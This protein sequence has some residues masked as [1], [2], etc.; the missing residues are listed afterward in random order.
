MTQPP[1]APRIPVVHRLHGVERI[2]DYDWMR[3]PEAARENLVAERR[4]YAAETAHLAP[5][6]QVLAA[7][8]A[9]RTPETESSVSW[10][11]GAFVYYTQIETGREFGD[12]CR[13]RDGSDGGSVLLDLDELATA[14]Y[15]ELGVREIS[16]CGRFLAYSVD[17]SGEEVYELRFRDLETGED[18]PDRVP[19]TYYT[20][21]WS[22]D[23]S[24]FFYTVVDDC[25]RPYEVR[26]HVLGQAEDAV[27]LTEA[28]RR[29]EV[30]V[31]A[32]RSG[33]YVVITATD[34]DTTEVWLIPAADP[35]A[36]PR[37]VR[38]RLPRV[39]YRVD[40]DAANDRLLVTTDDGWPE[41]RVLDGDQELFAPDA[42]ERVYRT[43][44]FAGHVV[45][46]L[47]RG[48]DPLLRVLPLDGSEPWEIHPETTAGRIELV[49]NHVYDTAEI[50]IETGSYSEPTRWSAVNLAT[51]ERTVL[52]TAET[53]GY[54]PADYVSERHWA[55]AAD[56]VLIPVTVVRR[57]DVP[58]DGTAPC[59]LYGYG[60]YEAVFDFVW[61]ASLSVLLDEGV[62]FAHAHIRGGGEM[63][64]AWWQA[65]RLSR[66]PTTFSDHVAVASWL[67]DKVSAIATRGL[68]AGGLL[69]AA[70]YGR[71]PWAAVIAEVPFVDVV[72]TMLDDSIPLTVNEWEE[73]GDPRK[74][75]EFAWMYAYSPYDN[76]PETTTPLLVTGAVNDPRVLVR[77]PAKWVAKLRTR[78]ANVLFRVEVEDGG[79]SGPTGRY[80]HLDYEAEVYA[81][82]LAA[83]RGTP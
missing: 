47:R 67:E 75:E 26:R 54:D 70:V 81:Y 58:L 4:H 62:I 61:D 31:E 64:R 34:R 68:S 80:A 44:C 55:P 16:P 32:T 45:V 30:T 83:L 42:A 5:F 29:F 76:I 12:F 78:G 66:K 38:G 48:G 37:S 28:D 21:A 41:F 15:V 11:H 17:T 65:G 50:M 35:G 39:E 19:G 46:S 56:G 71:R 25:Y 33:A 27:V 20:G 69:M 63:G 23:S 9:G 40:H 18:L 10:R 77:E 57:R 79:H 14:G 22:A 1:V 49:H 2:D 82:V 13:K 74:P 51:R 59:L 52:K 36:E 60:A 43:D 72:T 7:K 6:Q 3:D 24:S 73:W 8:M 53:P